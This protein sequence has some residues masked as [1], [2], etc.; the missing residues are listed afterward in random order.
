MKRALAGLASLLF[1]LMAAAFVV[2]L[3]LPK[4][5]IRA[6]LIS[7]IEER[8]GWR[9]RLDGPVGLSLLPGFRMSAENV[10]VSAGE[11]GEILRAETVNFGLA[12]SGL[13]GG[14]IR[15][16]HLRLD[17]P[18]VSVEID[19]NGRPNWTAGLST[20]AAVAT[21]DST[22]TAAAGFPADRWSAATQ[23]IADSN[24]EA[25]VQPAAEAGD[26]ARVPAESTDTGA[27]AASV[28]ADGMALARI[29]VDRLEIT[30]GRLI[31]S[32]R[33]D[34]TRHEADNVNVVLSLPSLSGALA[35]DGG[36]GYRGVAVTLAG[37]VEAPMR[38][39]GG[40]SSAVD[41]TLGGAGASA[42]ISGEL[43]PQQASRLRIAVEGEELGA[44]LAALGSSLPREPGPFR[45]TGDVTAGE[46]A[47]EIHG[48]EAQ[49]AGA[50]LRSSAT[51]ALAGE[52]QVTGQLE[53][54]DAR[55]ET[56]LSLAGRSE[57][58]QGTLGGSLRFSARGADA[59]TLMGS[60][61]A[62]GRLSL[63]GGG[64]SGLPV[65]SPIGDDASARRIE[66]LA[67]AIDFAGLDAPV[68]V[69]GGLKWRGDSFRIE[70]SATPALA[71]AGMPTPLRLRVAG[72]R[73]EVGYDGSVSP[74]G[75]VDGAVVLET[76]NLRALASWLGVPLAEGGGLGPFSF[77]G[78]L[79]AG[80]DA[81]RFTGA[82]IRL[83]DTTG[84]GEG[85][86]RLGARPKVTARLEL[87]RLGLDPYVVETDR[88]ND[89]RSEARVPGAER[90]SWSRVPIDLTGL[91]AVDAQLSL[92]AKQI[93][94]DKLEI[95]PSRLEL[96]L[97]GGR[98]SAELAEM[99]LY[100]GQGNGL[101]VLDGSQQVPEL[102]GRFSLT[103]LSARPFLAAVAGF[104]WIEGRVTTALDVKAHGVSQYELISGLDG[105]AR[106]DFADG[107]IRG[108]NIPRMVRGLTVDTLLGWASNEAQKTDFSALGASFTITRGIAA[109]EDLA[110]I[111]P[112]VRMSGTGRIDMP[113]RMLDWRLEPRVVA[114][115]EGS[116]P[117]PLAKGE[118]RELEGLGVP[119]IVR[120]S[121][122]RPQIYPDIKG[123]L[124]N[125]Q[126]AL[127]QLENLGGGLFKSLQQARNPQE[128]LTGVANEAINRAT[129]GNTNIDVQKVLDG[130][131]DDK[132][133]LE[134]VEQGFG[135]PSGFLGSFGIGRRQQ[136]DAAPQQ[137]QQQE[138][139]LPLDEAP[140]G[141]T[142]QQGAPIQ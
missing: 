101:L 123:I 93:V 36:L 1:L 89:G 40:G 48:L 38:L 80:E 96:T 107:A 31:Y 33:R 16:T 129:G 29:G 84:R 120:G 77:S 98:L 64:I 117:V 76:Q 75:A 5:A 106:F 135:L 15:L 97:E 81:V 69:S 138:E 102:A 103:D 85:E 63:A 130:E 50:S 17:A 13:F 118:A 91:R 10:G 8:T 100:G 59:A 2:P 95:G 19:E 43:A 37:T 18:V 126:A 32:D 54:A 34:G 60:L 4:D 46:R 11:A 141:E 7:Q 67:V 133:V 131:V 66:D 136:Q 53:L 140:Q 68:S 99:S 35:L 14:D 110:L 52:P 88:A 105:T 51:V 28:A 134:A 41:L 39:A 108:L 104:E 137:E 26:Q 116:A 112:L 78:R 92:S 114:S 115:L 139:Q 125:P 12:W 86:L 127:K 56:L 111:G 142:P 71:M 58:A 119:V 74:A 22:D 24:G 42:K 55:L 3:L 9:L 109:T 70:G 79:A 20:G 57:E 82:E 83:D 94:R 121:W 23:A 128:T 122:D 49:L 47:V 25:P 21:N 44:T 72:S 65:P 30:N 87:D 62:S 124:E 132:E 113:E 27:T 61:D 45:V 73:V 90:G 6:E